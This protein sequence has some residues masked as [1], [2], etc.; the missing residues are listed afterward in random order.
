MVRVLDPGRRASV[1]RPLIF[2]ARASG[3]TVEDARAGLVPLPIPTTECIELLFRN[4]VW[5]CLVP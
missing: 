3:V 1:R 2:R 4:R 5:L